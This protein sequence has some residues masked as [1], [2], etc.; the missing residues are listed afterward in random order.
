VY[1]Y[2]KKNEKI[3]VS[4]TD[5]S[6]L[7]YSYSGINSST[8]YGIEVTPTLQCGRKP[9]KYQYLFGEINKKNITALAGMYKMYNTLAYV[10][11]I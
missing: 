10:K 2:T 4:S 7:K 3:E 8:H 5:T 11:C 6:V 9:L 1:R